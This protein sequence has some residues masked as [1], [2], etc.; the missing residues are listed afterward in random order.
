[1]RPENDK[2]SEGVNISGGEPSGGWTFRRVNFPG[3]E[4]SGGETSGGE[5]SWGE[6]F[7]RWIIRRG[8]IFFMKGWTVR[9]WTTKGLKRPGSGFWLSARPGSIWFGD[10][11]GKMACLVIAPSPAITSTQAIQ[12]WRQKS[13]HHYRSGTW[14][15][16]TIV[17]DTLLRMIVG[18]IIYTSIYTI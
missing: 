3:G 12:R 18:Q 16:N 17:P 9:G 6:S 15:N 1:M 2:Y 4:T 7:G 5:T 10:S 13:T 14:Q 8:D 11:N